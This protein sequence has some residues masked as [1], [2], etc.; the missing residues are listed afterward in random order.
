M[1][2]G[3]ALSPLPQSKLRQYRVGDTVARRGAVIRE[4]KTTTPEVYW[5]REGEANAVDQRRAEGEAQALFR[6]IHAPWRT[7]NGRQEG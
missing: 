7:H 1:V 5:S 4:K 2:R 6:H 3:V